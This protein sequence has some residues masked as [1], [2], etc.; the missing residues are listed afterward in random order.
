MDIWNQ[1]AAPFAPEATSPLSADGATLMLPHW[2]ALVER[3]N[4]VAGPGGWSCGLRP[5][6]TPAGFAVV[7]RLEVGGVYREA[8]GEAA[9]L[10]QAGQV[11]LRQAAYLLGLGCGAVGVAPPVV[12]PAADPPKPDPHQLIDQLI[13]QLRKQGKGREVAQIVLKYQGYG[14]TLEESRRIYAEL[15]TLL[16]AQP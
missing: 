1:L 6:E 12:A 15:R 16:K 9:T 4:Q 10:A 2:E 8:I 14:T 13:E 5:F 3:L 7:G 11:A